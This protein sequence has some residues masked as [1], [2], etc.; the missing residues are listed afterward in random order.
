MSYNITKR[1]FDGYNFYSTFKPAVY[2]SI[3]TLQNTDLDY[4]NIST[5]KLHWNIS[6]MVR[7]AGDWLTRLIFLHRQLMLR[8]GGCYEFVCI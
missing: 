3:T 5:I 6:L 1:H 2:Y 4:A 8:P 7:A